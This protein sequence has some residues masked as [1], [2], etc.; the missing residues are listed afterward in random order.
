M[1]DP[2]SSG[3][4]PRLERIRTKA[5]SPAGVSKAAGIATIIAALMAGGVVTTCRSLDDVAAF[6]A[7]LGVPS[8]AEVA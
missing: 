3:T 5:R 7:V 2:G 1:S 6:L 4:H 8:R